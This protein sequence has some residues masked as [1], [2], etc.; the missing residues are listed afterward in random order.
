VP[1]RRNDKN[2]TVTRGMGAPPIA[3][4]FLALLSNLP[5]L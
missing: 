5:R 1:A 4:T 2:S 3:I